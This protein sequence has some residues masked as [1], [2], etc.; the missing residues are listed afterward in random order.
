[1]FKPLFTKSLRPLS[2]VG[3]SVVGCAGQ[4]Q[5]QTLTPRIAN[6]LPPGL[7]TRSF[8]TSKHVRFGIVED[9]KSLLVCEQR[10][11]VMYPWGKYEGDLVDGKPHGTGRMTFTNG[12]VWEG[13]FIKSV[14]NGY[15][16]K[17]Y[18]NGKV[19]EGEFKDNE[20]HGPGTIRFP[21][22]EVA[23]GMKVNGDWEGMV[24][25][26][27]PDGE[28]NET[29]HFH[30]EQKGPERIIRVGG[31][32]DESI[33]VKR[34]PHG[35]WKRT[36]PSGAVQVGTHKHGVKVGRWTYIV[37]GVTTVEDHSPSIR[38]RGR[39]WWRTFANSPQWEVAT[40]ANRIRI[41]NEI[42]SVL[43]PITFGMFIGDFG[44]AFFSWIKLMF[45][46]P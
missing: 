46:V 33:W 15:G 8:M 2:V 30:G 3:R 28:R 39:I 21:D 40:G 7:A 34:H 9:A 12:D 31:T 19:C 36:F 32:V 5:W 6:I 27:F 4:V 44:R 22:G 23:E 37:N 43:I 41:R 1:M 25:R 42:Y 17:S 18:S 10:A 35:P 24:K 20:M 38:D 29:F 14:M 16:K 26:T 13:R 11:T 45:V